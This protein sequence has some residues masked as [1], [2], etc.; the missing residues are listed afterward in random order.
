VE[1][2]DEADNLPDDML[3]STGQGTRYDIPGSFP[4][5]PTASSQNSSGDFNS[6]L[7]STIPITGY[8]AGLMHSNPSSTTG[9]RLIPLAENSRETQQTNQDGTQDP[10]N[11]DP[12]I[13]AIWRDIS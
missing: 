3:L 8:N 12:W 2:S 10:G 1:I 9:Y 13:R 7:P 6:L 4:L 5:E 11:I